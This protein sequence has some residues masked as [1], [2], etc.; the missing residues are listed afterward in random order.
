MPSATPR[1]WSSP[2][3]IPRSTAQST[4][5][6]A[7]ASPKGQCSA[8]TELPAVVESRPGRRSRGRSASGRSSSWR[9]RTER[10]P[11]AGLHLA[12]QAAAVGLADL[13]GHLPRPA[14]GRAARGSA[15]AGPRA[16]RRAAS[17]MSMRE[18][19]GDRRVALGRSARPALRVGAST[20]HVALRRPAARGGGA[21]RSGAD[22]RPWPAQRR[23]SGGGCAGRGRSTASWGRRRRSRARRPP[24][25]SRRPRR[26]LSRRAPRRRAVPLVTVVSVPGPVRRPPNRSERPLAGGGRDHDR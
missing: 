19:L 26:G 20:G 8:T 4:G 17:P 22:R 2:A 18:L 23:S 21:R 25:R 6:C 16:G 11:S 1:P 5:W 12:R 24:P 13:G 3:T 15:R 14:R 7:A 9:P 10:R